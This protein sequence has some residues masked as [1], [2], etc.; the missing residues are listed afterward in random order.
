MKKRRGPLL[1]FA[2][3]SAAA[4][5]LLVVFWNGDWTDQVEENRR[6]TSLATQSTA[7]A[8]SS[9]P[10]ASIA[11]TR[12]PVDVHVSPEATTARLHEPQSE[13]SGPSVASRESIDSPPAAPRD[14]LR[15][16]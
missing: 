16:V 1:L 6:T 11:G 9:M 10:S 2:L 5:F 15:G 3:L 12:E 4:V 14:E 13:S 8:G 7:R